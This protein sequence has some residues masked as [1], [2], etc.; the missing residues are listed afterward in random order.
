MQTDY[1]VANC[2]DPED[3]ADLAYGSEARPG[4]KGDQRSRNSLQS[5]GD[6]EYLNAADGYIKACGVQSVLTG[7]R[8]HPSSLTWSN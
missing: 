4:V 5:L 8:G 3:A 6:A 7:V 2:A 1:W